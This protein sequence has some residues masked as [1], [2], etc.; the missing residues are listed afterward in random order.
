MLNIQYNGGCKNDAECSSLFTKEK[1]YANRSIIGIFIILF[2]A[3]IIAH[4]FPEGMNEPS[5]LYSM[6]PAWLY[7]ILQIPMTWIF[8][9][10][11]HGFAKNMERQMQEEE[12]L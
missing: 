6:P 5:F 9:G 8:V 10:I 11:Y 3:S 4:F 2:P 12:P 1:A 7:A